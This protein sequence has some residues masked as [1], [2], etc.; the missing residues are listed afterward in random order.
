MKH[1]VTLYRLLSRD[2]YSSVAHCHNWVY[3]ETYTADAYSFLYR[4]A[5][6]SIGDPL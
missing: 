2:K 6:R 3:A 5:L 1:R 4:A